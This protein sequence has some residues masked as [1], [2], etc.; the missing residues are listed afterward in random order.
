MSETAATNTEQTGDAEAPQKPQAINPTPVGYQRRLGV[1]T[2]LTGEELGVVY[3]D[4]SETPWYCV[5]PD[6]TVR[7]FAHMA[8]LMASDSS[9]AALLALRTQS[10]EPIPVPSTTAEYRAVHDMLTRTVAPAQ[11]TYLDNLAV[12]VVRIFTPAR[13]IPGVPA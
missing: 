3:V 11:K 5:Y 7:S 12:K 10:W 1:F 13:Q 4:G 8:Q 2:T 6:G 9:T